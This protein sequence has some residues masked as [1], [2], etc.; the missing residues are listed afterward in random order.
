MNDG[1]RVDGVALAAHI[2]EVELLAADAQ[3]AAGTAQPLQHDAYGL[4]GRGF[5][6]IAD[7]A[8][9]N[10]AE[11]VADLA[12]AVRRQCDGLR[13]AA[14]AYVVTDRAIAAGFGELR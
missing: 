4:V 10:A 2:T 7:G 13:G 1:F 5:A 12:G 14:D 6:L 3:R 8:S 11:G 9:R